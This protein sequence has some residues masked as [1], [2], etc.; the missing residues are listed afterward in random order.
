MRRLLAIALA[1]ALG[2]TLPARADTTIGPIT[3]GPVFDCT[4][5]PGTCTIAAGGV[6]NAMLAGSIAAAKLAPLS[7]SDLRGLLTDETGSGAAVFGTSPTISAPTLSGTVAGTYT[8][9]GTPTLGAAL[10]LLGSGQISSAGWI[11]IGGTPAAQLHTQGNISAAA[12]TTNGIQ[13]RTS[14]ATLTD[15]SSSG[16]VAGVSASNFAVPTLAASN[17]T[18]YTRA[19][20]FRIG[21][22]PTAGT[23]VTISNG[24]A[25]WVA[26]G[27]SEFAGGV[28]IGA[29]TTNLTL[30]AAELGFE[31]IT[32]TGTAPGAGGGKVELVCGTNAGTAKII[33][34]A[35]TSTTAATVLDNIGSGVSGC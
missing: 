5:T 10:T 20:T 30:S 26:A 29:G 21:N 22:A 7:S 13:W 4:T 32:A 33:A 3:F 35:G 28:Q 18:T 14:A 23:N 25:L 17:S 27:K 11:G 34:Y 16:T 1:A 24:L 8:I 15:T 6:T 12:W 9:G 31:K 2:F 19:A